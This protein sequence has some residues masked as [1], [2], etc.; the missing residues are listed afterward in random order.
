[1][2]L[3]QLLV[4]CTDNHSPYWQN[5]WNEFINRYKNYIYK[6]V[7]RV[8]NDWHIERLQCQKSDFINDIVSEIFLELFKND[9]RVLKSYKNLD[10]EHLFLIWL[11]TLSTR[12]ARR[13]IEKHF[14]NDTILTDWDDFKSFR[15]YLQPDLCWELYD[16]TVNILRE[17]HNSENKERDIHIFMLYTWSNF[18][19]DIIHKLPFFKFLG[20]RVID[21]VVNRLRN[22]IRKE[23]KTF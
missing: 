23:R 18:S 5:A 14:R 22:T 3:Q 8:C 19:N 7:I 20:K 15:E 12:M 4:Y 17:K 1:M 10:Q 13:N 21:N 11:S 16:M 6:I 2:S 9:T